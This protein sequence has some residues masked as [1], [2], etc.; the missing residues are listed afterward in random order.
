MF[1]PQDELEGKDVVGKF[2]K[3]LLKPFLKLTA[4]ARLVRC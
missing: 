3:I 1:N 4:Q 2:L